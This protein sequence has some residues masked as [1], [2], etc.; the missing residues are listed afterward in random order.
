MKMLYSIINNELWQRVI[1]HTLAMATAASSSFKE[2]FLRVLA[3]R[4]NKDVGP[5][6][7][8]TNQ[9]FVI[10]D[11]HRTTSGMF[12]LR[13]WW[14]HLLCVF[15]FNSCRSWLAEKASLELEELLV[16]IEGVEEAHQNNP[17]YRTHCEQGSTTK[18]PATSHPSIMFMVK[19]LDACQ[20]HCHHPQ[21]RLWT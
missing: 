6:T 7:V 19:H 14:R 2:S 8:S 11:E 1:S 9:T 15:C 5:L 18:P 12:Q 21:L 16:M 10:L 4:P 3:N 17:I 13:W 20:E